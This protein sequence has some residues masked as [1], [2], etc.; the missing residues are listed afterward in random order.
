GLPMRKLMIFAIGCFS[1]LGIGALALAL[2]HSSRWSGTVSGELGRHL[3]ANR[4]KAEAQAAPTTLP[5]VPTAIVIPDCR[6]VP[7]EEQTVSSQRDGQIMFIARELEPGEAEPPA[8][9]L[10]TESV[11]LIAREIQAGEVVPEA[12]RVSVNVGGQTKVY[13]TLK[14]ADQAE[15]GKLWV[16]K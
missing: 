16:G 15:P 8:A 13:R 1:V 6:M 2:T 12:E 10:I 4:A 11:G 3:P 14:D 7:A 9:N 5:A